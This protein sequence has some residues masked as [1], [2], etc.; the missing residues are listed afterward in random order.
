MC[1]SWAQALQYTSYMITSF[2]KSTPR[3]PQS[4]TH[5]HF[6][7]APWPSSLAQTVPTLIAPQGLCIG[8]FFCR[9]TLAFAYLDG[10]LCYFCFVIKCH[11]I[12]QGFVASLYK[13]KTPSSLPYPVF[14]HSL[15]P[16]DRN[17]S[18]YY[19]FFYQCVCSMG[20]FCL[21]S[22]PHCLA[23]SKN[24]INMCWKNK[25]MSGF[26]LLSC[27]KPTS[28]FL[29]PPHASSCLV[30]VGWLEFPNRK[31]T[32]WNMFLTRWFSEEGGKR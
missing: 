17:T 14:H 15:W 5:G 12:K 27:S 29:S 19:V 1:W 25:Q 3:D 9:I 8:S 32:F 10:L 4:I 6:P 31:S 11:L 20:I 21:L 23:Q 24:W 28:T 2:S 30:A 22:F 7:Q 16:P 13:M 26:N 18:V